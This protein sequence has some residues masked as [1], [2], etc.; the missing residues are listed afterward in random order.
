MGIEK[1]SIALCIV[2]SLVTCGIYGLY[3][4]YCMAEDTNRVTGRVDGTTGGMVVLFSIITCGIYGLY[5]L[6]MC[7]DHLDSMR[8]EQGGAQ[9]HLALLYLLLSIFGFGI[10]SYALLQSELN[11][12]AAG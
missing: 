8:M 11:E 3:W 2:L 10:I 5:W 1:R 4:Q 7:G 12:Y 6:Y 9:G